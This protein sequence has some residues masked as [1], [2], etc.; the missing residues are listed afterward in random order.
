LIAR[1]MCVHYSP[2]D[3]EVHEDPY[4]VYALLRDAAPV[5]RNSE[6]GFWA[7]SR[8]SD[9]AA[10]LRDHALFSRAELQPGQSLLQPGEPLEPSGN[11][12]A[13]G[14]SDAHRTG[15]LV[16]MNPGRHA[17]LRTVISRSFTPRR[18]AR[19][20]PSVSDLARRHLEPAV[21][22]GS[23]DF[24]ADLA[25]PISLDVIGELIGVP[26]ADRD[27]AR[28]LALAAHRAEG[29][30]HAGVPGGPSGISSSA[31]AAADLIQYYREILAERRQQPAGDLASWVLSLDTGG[32]RLTEEEVIGVLLALLAGA[33]TTAL[34]LG[35]AWYW[36]W[37]N[38]DQRTVPFKDPD[39]IPDWIEETLRYDSSSQFVSRTL[40]RDTRL[41]GELIPAGVMVLLLAGSANRDPRAF[42][43]PDRLDLDRDTSA[44]IGFGAGRHLC[45]GA[46]LARLTARIV[47]TELIRRV[48]DYDI[49]TE[50]IRRARSPNVR[51]FDR[52]PTTVSP[53]TG[54]G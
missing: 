30:E 43:D 8:Y 20:E 2:Y 6:H 18:A 51:G 31:A 53:R 15:S 37:R 19:L 38:P 40:A 26:E 13:A 42:P 45:L 17:Q 16:S 3:H 46:P 34:L 35:N 47:L 10:A 33:N 24:I 39:R 32:D 4:P 14:G 22:S 9:V 1:V 5:Y 27:S 50:G 25:E 52:L 49:G 41:H 44:M 48:R 23:F 29:T 21:G 7:L 28:R 11:P 36:A 54:W 12:D